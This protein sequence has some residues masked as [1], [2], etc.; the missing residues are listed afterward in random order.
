MRADRPSIAESAAKHIVAGDLCIL[1]G[2]VRDQHPR[3]CDK[4]AFFSDQEKARVAA[5]KST[6]RRAE[7]ELGRQLLRRTL[8]ACYRQDPNAILISAEDHVKPRLLTDHVE[9]D[10]PLA[11]N[12]SHSQ[13][14]VVA[15]FH[16]NGPLGVDIECTSAIHINDPATL[17][18][19][20][21]PDEI[22]FLLAQPPTTRQALFLG[23]WQRKEAVIKALGDGFSYQVNGFTTLDETKAF[24]AHI[25]LQGKTWQVRE[26]QL[27]QTLSCAIALAA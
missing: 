5:F 10:T 7:F 17:S 2:H 16:K 24:R 1:Y 12:L 9:T 13:G 27:S 26:V 4:G 11:F 3:W 18:Q 14:W 19:V 21:A 22:A 6:K 20:F 25:H 23:I 8:S 15:A